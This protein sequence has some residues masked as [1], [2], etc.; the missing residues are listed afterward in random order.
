MGLPKGHTNNPNGRPIGSKNKTNDKIRGMVLEF[1]DQNIDNIQA[2]YDKLE[3]KERLQFFEKLL[4]YALPKM[5]STELEH[6][7]SSNELP[8]LSIEQV[9]KLIEKL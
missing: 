7:D 1:I 4:N 2:D 8:R 6:W 9:D 3:P 5:Q